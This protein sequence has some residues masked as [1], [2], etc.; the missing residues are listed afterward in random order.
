MNQMPQNNVTSNHDLAR[1]LAIGGIPV[2]PCREADSDGKKAKA[3]YTASGFKDATTDLEQVD[4]WWSHH[5]GAVPG[6]PTGRASGLAVID[7][8]VCKETGEAVGKTEIIDLG[9]SDP[10]A[11][12][13]NT[14]SGGVHYIFRHVEGAGCTTKQVASH[15]D[16]RGDGGYIIAPGSM[17]A[18]GT[19]YTYAGRTLA[20]ALRQGV[21]PEYPLTAVQ[22][23]IEA[24]K[25][26]RHITPAK[27]VFGVDAGSFGDTQ[28]TDDETLE[29]LSRLL[30]TAPNSLSRG[31]WVKLALSLKAGFGETLRSGFIAFS[32]RYSGGTP[33]DAAEASHVWQSAD[34]PR[35]ITGIAP[36]LAL[37]KEA[38]GEMD[39]K[40]AWRET[41]SKRDALALPTPRSAP[42]EEPQPLVREIAPGAPY[43]EEALGGLRKAVE[44]VQGM[45]QAPVAIPA[46][47]ALCV[48]S[49]AVQGFANVET[50]GGLRPVSLYALTIAQS[51]ERKSSCDAPLM[52][53]LRDHERE[54][55]IAQRDDHASWVNA[56]ALWKGE[57]D[58]ILAEAKKGKGEKRTAAQADLAALG[59]E[60]AAPPSTDRTVTEPTFEGLTRLFATGQPSLG[61]FSDEGGQFLGGHAM[62]SD[63]RQK[64]LAA[65]NDLWQG[66]PIRRTRAGDGHATLYGRRLAVHLMVQ[67][68][69]ARAFM[70]DRMAT[71]TGFL[72][73]FLICEPPSAIGRREHAKARRDDTALAEFAGR[74]QGI[75]ARPMPMDPETR[76]L[77]PRE[78]PL[79]PEA[80]ALLIGFFD[81]IE[82]EQ[83]PGGTLAHVTGYASKAAEQAARIAGVQTLW[84]DLDAP[85]VTAQDMANGIALAQYY[86][87]EAVRLTDAANTS[88][89]IDRAEML[90]KWLLE[91]WPHPE[92]LKSE[93]VQFGPNQ[94]RESPKAL[95]AL[96]VLEQHGWLV[97]LDPGAIVRGKSRKAAWHIVRRGDVV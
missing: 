6:I 38:V 85:A 26:N 78:L 44:A 96:R 42:P 86:L 35:T 17:M 62:N 49:L 5:P 1:R 28:A 47:S 90:R 91:C 84:R 14:P 33:C 46:A 69:V 82:L 53:A 30:A 2:F 66:N 52:A 79:A 37:L 95:A 65:L 50:L 55:A 59:K 56:Q 67:P 45:T 43:P 9:L 60:P 11:V 21:L 7:G 12:M 36:A 80:R 57:R 71:E 32:L 89:E 77:Q 39:W 76:E 16:T 74:L 63:N 40:E 97:P 68:R 87:S 64:T 27:A 10:L 31:D 4:L 18:N 3:P 24:H 48:A 83:A 72:P 93:V 13:V 25:R 94:L 29:V 41:L 34:T 81:A 8:D 23:A 19:S 88:E 51:G 73:R 15:V 58:R 70:A 61:I 22:A 54:Q 75:L 92:I 20:E